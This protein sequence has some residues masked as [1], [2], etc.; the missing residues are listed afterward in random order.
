MYILCDR[1]L[2]FHCPCCSAP[3]NSQPGW[4]PTLFVRNRDGWQCPHQVPDRRAVL[5]KWELG[6]LELSKLNSYMMLQ[7]STVSCF[8]SWLLY[9]MCFFLIC[10]MCF[11]ALS[12][13]DVPFASI[14]IVWKVSFECSKAMWYYSQI[15]N[16]KPD[17]LKKRTHWCGGNASFFGCFTYKPFSSGSG[18]GD[19]NVLDQLLL[20]IYRSG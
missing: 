5:K 10:T 7:A 15:Q 14:K 6:D 16:A 19:N 9:H 11:W 4:Q 13:K 17:L 8:V 18:W 2:C 3:K 12:A 20:L 1:F